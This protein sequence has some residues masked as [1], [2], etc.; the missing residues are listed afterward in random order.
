MP[1]PCLEADTDCI[2]QVVLAGICGSDLHPY[3]LRE[4]GIEKGCVMGHEFVGVISE[5]GAAVKTLKPGAVM[6]HPA[7]PGS[8]PA[9]DRVLTPFTTSCGDCWYCTDGNLPCRCVKGQL[10]GWREN[11]QGLHGGQAEYVRVPLADG[12][13]VPIREGFTDIEAL[14]LGDVLSTGYHAADNAV[15]AAGGTKGRT[16]C[17]VGLGPVGLCACASLIHLGAQNVFAIDSVPAR[18][19]LAESYGAKPLELSS[20]VKQAV[21]D[22]TDGRGADGAVEAV[23]SASALQS[24]YTLLRPGGVLSSVGV[25]NSQHLPFTPADCYDKNLTFISGRCPARY[26]MQQAQEVIA[27][28]NFNLERIVSHRVPFSGAPEAYRMFDAKLDGCTKVVLMPNNE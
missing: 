25:C 2:V 19:A 10:F 12:T 20:D 5:A 1:K 15:V 21:L 27:S 18:L 6:L 13:L 16:F 28:R 22:A 7:R 14:L 4:E 11:G 23:G 3:N 9:G 8:H 24:A 17:V 26:R